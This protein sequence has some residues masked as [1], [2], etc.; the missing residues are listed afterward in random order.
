[1]LLTALAVD[2][3]TYILMHT[4]ILCSVVASVLLRLRTGDTAELYL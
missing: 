1:M 3:V 4:N 2:I